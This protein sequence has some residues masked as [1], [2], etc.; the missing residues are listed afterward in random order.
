VRLQGPIG[1][2]TLDA[3]AERPVVMLAGGIGITPF[4][5]MLRQAADEHQRRQLYLFYSNRTPQS[6]PFLPELTELARRNPHF[7]L[8]ATMTDAN[9]PAEHWGGTRG[10][11]GEDMLRQR[12]SDLREPIYY[13][14]GPPRMVSAMQ[15]MLNRAGI[16][17]EQIRKDEFFGY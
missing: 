5:S 16:A 1:K 14:A 11:I 9:V 10:Y 8:T 15:S 6:A 2:F 13:V 12:L 4:R 7:V 3:E 17:G